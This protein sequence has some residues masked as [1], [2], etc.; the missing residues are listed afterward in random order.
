MANKRQVISVEVND[1]IERIIEDRIEF[2]KKKMPGAK[3]TTSDVVR[4]ALYLLDKKT[5][6]NT[7]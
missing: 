3:I 2:L 4:E 7:K 6:R 5:K 1:E